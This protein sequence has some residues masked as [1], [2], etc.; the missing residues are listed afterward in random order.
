M[1]VH[2]FLTQYMRSMT[3]VV[4]E[5]ERAF[6]V[7]P[8][9]MDA[10][11]AALGGR[12]VDFAFLT[13]EHYD[14]ISGTDWARALGAEIVASAACDRNLGDVKLNHSKYYGAFCAAQERLRGDPIP[15]VQ[16]YATHADR[17]FEEELTTEWNGHALFFR[18]TPGHSTGG[19]CLL[20]DGKLLFSGDT[21]FRDVLSNPDMMC[22]SAEDLAAST[23]WVLSLP[24]DVLVYPGHYESF[25]V[26]ERKERKIEQI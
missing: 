26:R 5:G 3:Y 23:A 14:H 6:L 9:E 12:T 15:K 25:T 13:H 22:G 24:E 18:S 10:V 16:A 1:E 8:C 11:K 17:T 21:V 20:V 2:A 19:A 7:D 4:T